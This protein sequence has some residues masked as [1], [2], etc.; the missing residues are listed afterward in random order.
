M[1][2]GFYQLVDVLVVSIGY[3]DFESFEIVFELFHS[4][5]ADDRTGD[6]RLGEAPGDRE[7]RWGAVDFCTELQVILHDGKGAVVIAIE[8]GAFLIA[9]SGR[10]SLSQAV[11]ACEK[12]SGYR[13][14]GNDPD[15][16]GAAEGEEFAFN[17][18]V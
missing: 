7:V 3:V 4:A 1:G 18:S 11:F 2:S 5:R 17:A 13:G 9:H 16:V 15:T 12:S 14:P 6:T 8:E 10:A